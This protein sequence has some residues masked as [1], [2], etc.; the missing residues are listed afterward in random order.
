MLLNFCYRTPKRTDRG[1]IE[2]QGYNEARIINEKNI[3]IAYK[4]VSKKFKNIAIG[5]L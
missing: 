1:A 5:Y 4:N 2:L 3:Y